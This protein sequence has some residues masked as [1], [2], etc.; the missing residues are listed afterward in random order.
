L[1][2]G[3]PPGAATFATFRGMQGDPHGLAHTAHAAG[4]ITSVP[5]APRD[6]LFFLLHCNVDRLWAKWQWATQLHDPTNPR[7]FMALAGAF[8]GHSLNDRLWPWCGPNV[9]QRPPVAPR[10][11]FAPSS[12]TAAPPPQPRV[13][14]MIDYLGT[15]GPD[16]LAFAYD[17]VPFQV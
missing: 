17:D 5:T 6:P 1:A 15:I 13:R 14:D 8:P 4:W 2:L 16:D 11:P 12:M 10:T 7:S 9:P 3:G